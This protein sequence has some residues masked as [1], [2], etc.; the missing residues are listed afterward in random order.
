MHAGIDTGIIIDFSH[1]NSGKNHLNQ[2]KVAQDV[3]QQIENGNRKIIGVMIEANIHE[4]AQKHTPG[5][6]NPANI[7]AGISITDACVSL[8][9]NREMLARL[10]EATARRNS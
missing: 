3:A 8:E 4:G 9:T 7:Q 10:E 1:A 2:P 5:K 6:D